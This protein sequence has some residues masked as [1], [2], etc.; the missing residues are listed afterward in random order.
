MTTAAGAEEG[1]RSRVTWTHALD[2]AVTVC[3]A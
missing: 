1:D 3:C 2:Y